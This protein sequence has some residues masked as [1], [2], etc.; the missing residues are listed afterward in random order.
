MTVGYVINTLEGVRNVAWLNRAELDGVSGLALQGFALT[1]L[2]LLP[3]LKFL[4]T[5]QSHFCHLD[6]TLARSDHGLV[7]GE[8]F[9]RLDPSEFVDTHLVFSIDP[10]AK[11]P[12]N[13]PQLGDGW[14]RS[15][16]SPQRGN[17]LRDSLRGRT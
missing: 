3:A 12:E 17:A 4:F 7:G 9:D 1:F 16:D 10:P 11:S 2:F 5:L 14:L 8:R 6:L 13:G 15:I